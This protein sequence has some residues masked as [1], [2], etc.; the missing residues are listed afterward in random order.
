MNDNQFKMHFR[1]SPTTFEDLIVKVNRIIRRNNAN[2]IRA[3][4]PTIDIE[5][6]CM[7]MIWCLGNME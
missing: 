6:E 7:I 2:I 5:K 1:M 4:R 3:G